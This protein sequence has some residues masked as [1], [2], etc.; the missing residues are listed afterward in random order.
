[1]RKSRNKKVLRRELGLT[2][3]KRGRPKHAEYICKHCGM[4][5]ETVEKKR[6]HQRRCKKPLSIGGSN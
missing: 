5:L 1:M 6:D 3:D 2:T 4:R